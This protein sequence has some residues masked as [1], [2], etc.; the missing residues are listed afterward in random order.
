[1]NTKIAREELR[2][3]KIQIKDLS[4]QGKIK[5]MKELLLTFYY[6]HLKKNKTQLQEELK[7]RKLIITKI[8]NNYGTIGTIIFS[9]NGSPPKGHGILIGHSTQQ[10]EDDCFTGWFT[11]IGN[12]KTK[13]FWQVGVTGLKNDRLITKED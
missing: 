4:E 11:L 3:I 7:F 12:G 10:I 6:P 5:D 9:L 8:P 13:Q 2:P 1:M